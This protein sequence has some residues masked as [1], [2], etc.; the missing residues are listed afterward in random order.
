MKVLITGGTGF[1]GYHLGEFLSNNECNVT[2]V[3]NLSKAP[4]DDDALALV[5]RPN[6]SFTQIDLSDRNEVSKLD[7]DFTH[8][9]HFAALLGVQNVLKNSF[10]V[11]KL[12]AELVVNVIELAEQQENLKQFLF[13]STSEIYAGTLEAGYLEIPSPETSQ[14]V[15]PKL[16]SPRTSYMLSK[17][18]GEALCH[19]SNLPYTILR[20]HNIYGPRMGMR[21][22]IP[23]LLRKACLNE[24]QAVEVFSMQHS[25]TFCYVTDAVNM[26]FKLMK[27]KDAIGQTFNIGNQGPEIKMGDLADLIINVVSK[28]LAIIDMGTTQGSPERRAPKMTR[29]ESL[30]GYKSEVTLRDGIQKCEEWYR[31]NVF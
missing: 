21:H 2:L 18:Y 31:A 12:N 7:K 16:E 29:L 23:E 17:I 1:I 6:V 14:L 8:I 3:D 27:S 10:D 13:A 19:H 5:A 9:V 20:P 28:D 25:R 26:I 24:A 22:V 11:L 4:L 30:T 15:L